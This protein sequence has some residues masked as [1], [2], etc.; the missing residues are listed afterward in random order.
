MLPE[1]NDADSAHGATMTRTHARG[2]A[3]SCHGWAC[4]RIAMLRRAGAVLRHAGG[5]LC[6]AG[7][8]SSLAKMAPFSYMLW[9]ASPSCTA[10]RKNAQ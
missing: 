6:F 5:M 10:T 9:N 7:A 4:N 1:H 3:S 2:R 8:P